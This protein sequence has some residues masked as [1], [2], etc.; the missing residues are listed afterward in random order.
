MVIVVHH[1]TRC[2]ALNFWS[3]FHT[4]FPEED[5]RNADGI[6]NASIRSQTKLN[7]TSVD[8]GKGLPKI[9]YSLGL[10]GIS[11]L[12]GVWVHNLSRVLSE[13]PK[14]KK[15]LLWVWYKAIFSLY[16]IAT[17]GKRLQTV[18]KVLKNFST[19]RR[20]VSPQLLIRR[21]IL[22]IVKL[23]TPSSEMR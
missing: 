12:V 19:I 1:I 4:R 10:A 23:D 8:F 22:G 18:F 17:D 11:V 3:P 7:E 14:S 6:Q 5:R 9:Y 16:H 20:L 15:I 21:Y 13:M 2:K